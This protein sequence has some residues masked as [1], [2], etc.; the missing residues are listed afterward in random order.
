MDIEAIHAQA[1]NTEV[2]IK[3]GN[4]SAPIKVIE[5]MN[6]RCPYCR[7][8]FEE[9]ADLL[10]EVVKADKA[11]RIIK[12]FDKEKPSLQR[13]NVMHRYVPFEDE[14]K[15]L[16]VLNKIYASQAEWGNLELEEV[17]NYAE[18]QLHLTPVIKEATTEAIIAEASEANITL[19]PTII[20]GETIFDESITQE[21]L[22]KLL[23]LA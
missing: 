7:K 16:A 13:G 5:F 2:G 8:W 21:E 12:L 4:D 18:T 6:V 15:T 17:K 20:I 1:T 10:E 9:S 3:I 23:E 19:V 11:Q 14:E 22:K